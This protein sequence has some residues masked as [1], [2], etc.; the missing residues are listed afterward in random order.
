MAETQ[1]TKTAGGFISLLLLGVVAWYFFG[2]GVEN[3]VADE[4]LDQYRIA[5]R[6]GSPMDACVQ[7]GIVRAA[8]LQA[9]DE[10]NYQRWHMTEQNDCRLA[11]VPDLAQ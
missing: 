4:V 1:G 2:G 9:K 10:A 11:G 5:K 6:S 8:Y 3:K 7:A